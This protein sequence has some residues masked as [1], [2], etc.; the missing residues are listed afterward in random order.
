MD[1]GTI[2][3]QDT[4]VFIFIDDD[5]VNNKVCQLLIRKMMPDASISAFTD[6]EEGVGYFKKIYEEDGLK[7]II[8]FLDINMPVMSGWEVLEELKNLF[9]GNKLIRI[10]MLSSSV[11]PS[12]IEKSKD[13]YLEGYIEKPLSVAKL[14]G[15][16]KM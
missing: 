12:D 10:Y 14:Q 13:P 3:P 11:D 1:N 9:G 5:F 6:P 4:P 2:A 15:I 8:L 7:N 16:L